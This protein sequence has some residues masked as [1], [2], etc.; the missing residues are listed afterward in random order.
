MIVSSE[1]SV[2]TDREVSE[3]VSEWV[4]NTQIHTSQ[5]IL[6]HTV[7]LYIPM[8]K[9]KKKKNSGKSKRETET[10]TKKRQTDLKDGKFCRVSDSNFTYKR[11]K[12][13]CCC[14]ERIDITR[15]CPSVHQCKTTRNIRMCGIGLFWVCVWEK[16]EWVVWDN[17]KYKQTHTHSLSLSLSHRPQIRGEMEGRILVLE[18]QRQFVWVYHMHL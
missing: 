6:R 14:G 4:N 16:N 8:E 1:R 17:Y 9:K 11:S 2:T 18:R 3:W 15:D 12:D 10:H 7:D 13:V 5:Q